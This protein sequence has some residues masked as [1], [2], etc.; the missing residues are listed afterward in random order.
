MHENYGTPSFYVNGALQSFG[1]RDDVH[2]A[3]TGSTKLVSQHNASTS[4]WGNLEVGHY[5]NTAS[6]SYNYKGKIQYDRSMPNG[7]LRKKLNSKRINSLGWKSKIN[8]KDGLT[9]LV[10]SLKKN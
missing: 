2:D 9:N 7:T 3:L 10:H 1:D 5:N 6:S 8:L 4:S